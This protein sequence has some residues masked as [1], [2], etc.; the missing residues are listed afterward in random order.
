M[1][2]MADKTARNRP[3]R[4]RIK[5]LTQAAMN[6]DVTVGQLEDLLGGL[7]ETLKDLNS[8][9]ARLNG[10]VERLDGG[11]DHFEATLSR[12]DDLMGRLV[13]LVAPIEAIVERIDYIVGVG[14]TVMTPVSTTEHA[15]RGMLNALRNRTAR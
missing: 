8:S 9:L 1:I 3:P 5:T 4:E 6:A 2:G 7:G 11:L 14:E 15:I 10:A 13:T 12:I